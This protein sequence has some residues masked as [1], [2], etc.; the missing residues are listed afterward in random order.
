MY[1][2]VYVLLCLHTQDNSQGNELATLPK[3]DATTETHNRHKLS[4]ISYIDGDLVISGA[5]TQTL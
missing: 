1:K 4:D 5:R 2:Y 3:A